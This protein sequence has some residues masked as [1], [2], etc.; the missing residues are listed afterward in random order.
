MQKKVVPSSRFPAVFKNCRGIIW[1]HFPRLGGVCESRAC[2][3]LWYP[4]TRGR[5]TRKPNF[6]SFFLSFWHIFISCLTIPCYPLNFRPIFMEPK[7][8]TEHSYMMNVNMIPECSKYHSKI[9]D[10]PLSALC[11]QRHLYIFLYF[12]TIT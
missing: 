5:K 12:F 2:T 1:V 3:H 11:S 9:H 4:T 10:Q 8:N 6:A 7:C